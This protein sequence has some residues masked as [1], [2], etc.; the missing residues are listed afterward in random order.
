[1]GQ[2]KLESLT[3]NAELF[4]LRIARVSSNQDNTDP[5]LLNYLIRNKH[6]SPFEHAFATFEIE[7][8]RAIAAQILRHRS[9]TFQEFSLRYAAASGTEKFKA[10]RQ[11]I[12]NRQSST[13]DLNMDV[14]QWYDE[15]QRDIEEYTYQR[16]EASLKNGI[17]KEQA[18][19]L[20]PM[21]TVTKL[22][23]TGSIRSWIHYFDIRCDEHTQQEH[24][25]LALMMRAL[26]FDNDEGALPIIGQA[27]TMRDA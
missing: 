25:V 22:Y 18:R 13:D 1:M 4:I 5:G 24:R 23:M 27:L 9:F 2:V 19:F 14:I 12:T 17:A 8:N 16:Y 7:T 26:L 10:R 21:A 3:P 15:T 6:W 11:G 20:L